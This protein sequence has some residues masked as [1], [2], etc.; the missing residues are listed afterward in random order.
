MRS[1]EGQVVGVVNIAT[2]F[3]D[4]ITLISASAW[5]VI[6]DWFCCYTG[7]VGQRVS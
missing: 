4:L 3:C 1:A 6:A 2:F 7:S 5:L